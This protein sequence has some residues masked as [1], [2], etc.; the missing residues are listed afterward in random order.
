MTFILAL[1]TAGIAGIV[2]AATQK[3]RA[4]ARIPVRIKDAP[5]RQ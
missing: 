5:P 1:I 3:T 4:E 2:W